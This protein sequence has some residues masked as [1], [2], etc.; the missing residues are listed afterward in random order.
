MILDGIV[1]QIFGGA[2]GNAGFDSQQA[3]AHANRQAHAQM[4]AQ[5]NQAQQ[6]K[7]KKSPFDDGDVI[8]VEEVP[9]RPLL[10]SGEEGK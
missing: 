3:I 4:Q 6:A 2:L 9:T 10:G 1:G 5:F 8:D 7:A